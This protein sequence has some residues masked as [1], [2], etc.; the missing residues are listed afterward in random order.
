MIDPHW[1]VIDLDP[2]TWRSLGRFFD[3]GQYIRS[4]QPGEHALFILHDQGRPLRV[5]DTEQGVLTHLNIQS[6][7]DP[8]TLA[9]SLYAQ[10][11]WQRVHVINKSHLAN[12]A[13]L[14]QT[15]PAA[16]HLDTYY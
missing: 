12:V 1:S 10:G 14:A 2:Y 8:Q 7:D 5:V 11:T 4:A 16:S 3:P 13:R 15:S 9:R 6:I